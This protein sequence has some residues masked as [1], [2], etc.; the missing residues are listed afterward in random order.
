MKRAPRAAYFD[1]S[2]LL[3]RYVQEPHT[4]QAVALIK[5]HSVV[6]AAIAPLEAVS[7]LRRLEATGLLE[8]QNYRAILK[9]IQN[10]RQ[11]WDLIGL[12]IEILQSAERIVQDCN[13]RCL[14]A[15]HLASANS[16]QS[17]LNR[18]LSFVTADRQQRK[19]ASQINIEV[20]WLE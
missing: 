10:D 13:V 8:A 12:S 11:T 3:K 6:T 20:L 9:R 18:P 5:R 17:R 2:V 19:A 7:A 16:F 15:I 1:T 4:D 14:D